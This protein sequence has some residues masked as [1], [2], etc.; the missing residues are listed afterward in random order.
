MHYFTADVKGRQWVQQ[1][2]GFKPLVQH[3]E[4]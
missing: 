3:I 2:D 4:Q 1:E